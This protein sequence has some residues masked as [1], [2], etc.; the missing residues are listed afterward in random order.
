MSLRI[1]RAIAR[2]S[3]GT[4]IEFDSGCDSC[5]GCSQGRLKQ[6]LVPGEFDHEVVVRL[7]SRDQLFALYHSLLL[8]ILMSV[9]SALVADWFRLGD[10]Y[11]SFFAIGGFILGMALCRQLSP[12]TLGI[13]EKI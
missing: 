10:L 4:L 2:D 12:A 5:N 7:S 9:C 11:A 3:R 6:L 13:Q 1:G 8:P